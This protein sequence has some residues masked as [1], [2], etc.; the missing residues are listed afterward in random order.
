M[1]ALNINTVDG[2]PGGRLQVLVACGSPR[3][4]DVVRVVMTNPWLKHLVILPEDARLSHVVT[5]LGIFPST[6][7]ARKNGWDGDIPTG[8]WRFCIGKLRHT[9]VCL[10]GCPA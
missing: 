8:V 7:Q 9:V 4:L 1:V 3:I 10:K 6:S 2:V 5:A